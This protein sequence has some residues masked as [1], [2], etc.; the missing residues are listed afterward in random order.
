M[1]S[2]HILNH[3]KLFVYGFYMISLEIK[4]Q[5]C[6]NLSKDVIWI[7][8]YVDATLNAHTRRERMKN[9][10]NRLV[11]FTL[12]AQTHINPIECACARALMWGG[13]VLHMQ[14]YATAGSLLFFGA[15][16]R[17]VGFCVWRLFYDVIYTC[18]CTLKINWKTKI[19][20]AFY[21]ESK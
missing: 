20:T 9:S 11:A 8:I 7:R 1:T 3:F 15:R 18:T 4:S 6:F 12:A 13:K 21:V 10:T 19:I 2:P 5:Y 16:A 17:F 14:F